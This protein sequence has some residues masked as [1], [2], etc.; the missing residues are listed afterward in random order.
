MNLQK[1]TREALE[2]LYQGYLDIPTANYDITEIAKNYGIPPDEFGTFLLSNGWI[3]NQWFGGNT[4]S[5]QIT[6]AGIEYINVGY[7]NSNLERVVSTLGIHGGSGS[8]MEALGFTEGKDFHRAFD[9]A[10]EFEFTGLFNQ[11][12]YLPGDVQLQLSLSGYEY[13]N[14]EKGASFMKGY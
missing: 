2:H 8:L 6:L 3:R 13:Y 4:F 12:V 14:S 10:K 9:L 5:A 7:L 1:A 11:P